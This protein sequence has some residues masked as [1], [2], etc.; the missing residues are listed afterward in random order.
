[1]VRYRTNGQIKSCA[2][3]INSFKIF[4]YAY[5]MQW[6]GK[7]IGKHEEKRNFEDLG[8]NGANI[9]MNLKKN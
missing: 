4:V 9:K 5:S 6:I 8:V 2:E 3:G 7:I 1:M